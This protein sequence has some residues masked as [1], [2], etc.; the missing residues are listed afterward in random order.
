MEHFRNYLLGRR[1]HVRT[2]QRALLSA[3]KENRGNKTQYSRL[4]R[5]VDRLIPF[6]FSIEHVP[7]RSMGWADFLSHHPVGEASPISNYDER[8]VIAV[9][10]RI[11][12]LIG[13]RLTSQT[14]ERILT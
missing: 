11:T 3:L 14:K 2:D 13:C 6:S 1:F 8:F 9:I 10:T 4:T 5:W 7:G 12:K